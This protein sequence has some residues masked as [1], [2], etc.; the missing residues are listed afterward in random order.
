MLT[1]HT[2]ARL[3]SQRATV[4]TLDLCIRPT[5][6][7]TKPVVHHSEA[8]VPQPLKMQTPNSRLRQRKY[9][10]LKRHLHS[11]QQITNSITIFFSTVIFAAMVYTVITFETTKDEYRGGRTAWPKQPKTWPM[12]ML[13]VCAG[14]TLSLS[15]ITLFSYCSAFGKAQQSWKL[16]VGTYV[17]RIGTWVV[18]SVLYRYERSTHGIPDD[19]WGWSCSAKAAT[20]QTQFD[21]VVAFSTMC[22]VQVSQQ[23]YTMHQIAS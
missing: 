9:Q 4:A 3:S 11:G 15:I 1:K 17:I 14:I 16:T 5:D 22:S 8:A 19:I 7:A 6:P 13:L 20:L 10:T 12:F 2:A 18:V 21:G 23:H